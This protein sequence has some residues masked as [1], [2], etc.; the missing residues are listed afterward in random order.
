[1]RAGTVACVAILVLGCG[2][3]AVAP[4]S[5]ETRF[6][7]AL[8]DPDVRVRIEAVRALATL[9]GHAAPLLVEALWDTDEA[10]RA[11][12][13][14]ELVDMGESAVPALVDA[15]ADDD[16][17]NLRR[18][19]AEVL[20]RMGPHARSAVPT[21]VEALAD[22]DAYLRYRA[23]GAL[24]RIGPGASEAVPAL[25]WALGDGEPR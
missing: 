21:L 2:T 11:L 1:M 25:V 18:R 24:E 12:V 10:V 9:G 3:T 20:G 23:A 17:V 4:S 7:I 6:G 16:L 14:S 8:V 15:V 13:T 5:P 22:G 19:A